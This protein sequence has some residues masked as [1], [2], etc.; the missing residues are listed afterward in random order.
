[1]NFEFSMKKKDNYLLVTCNG[2]FD[3]ERL[4]D[5]HQRALDYALEEKLRAILVD[6]TGL[7]GHN[8]SIMERFD[9]GETIAS[10]QR[11]ENSRICIAFIG[12]EPVVDPRR[13]GET[14]VL[15]RGGCGKVFE[16]SSEA[17]SWIE[18]YLTPR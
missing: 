17:L 9:F 4:K 14:V 6:A 18:D 16:D 7:R 1:M 2:P 3:V 13:F 12:K 8:P 5:V 11:R 15:N 10:L